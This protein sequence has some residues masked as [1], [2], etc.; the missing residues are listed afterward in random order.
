QLGVPPRRAHATV[1]LARAVAAGTLRLEPGCDVDETRR[2]LAELTGVSDRLAAM[3]VMRALS[4]PD[5]LPD[6][7]LLLQAAAGSSGAA[8]LRARAE[9]WRPWRAYAAAH[10]WLESFER[11]HR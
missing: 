1:T 3:I 8:A 7:D 4:W 10:L 11:N 5:A 9:A 2:A 6:A